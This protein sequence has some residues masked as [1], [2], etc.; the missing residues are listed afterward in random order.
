MVHRINTKLDFSHIFNPKKCRV[1]TPHTRE[2]H[3]WI[4]QRSF[5]DKSGEML[6]EILTFCHF[7]L[8]CDLPLTQHRAFLCGL[9]EKATLS[10]VTIFSVSV[11]QNSSRSEKIPQNTE[12][13]RRE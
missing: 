7:D 3:L 6:Q 13:K 2:F 5:A 4:R 12:N 10:N 8:H 9:C 11:F 1:I